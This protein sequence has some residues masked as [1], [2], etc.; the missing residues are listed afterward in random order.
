MILFPDDIT[1]VITDHSNIT[2]N[3]YVM[4]RNAKQKTDIQP[5]HTEQ[6]SSIYCL[7]NNTVNSS[8]YRVPIDG[9]INEWK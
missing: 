5:F 6:L 2:C 7:F 3:S 8:D 1:V 4:S 9:M